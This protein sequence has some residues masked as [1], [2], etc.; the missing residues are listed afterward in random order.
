MN[1]IVDLLYFKMGEIFDQIEQ[2]S[3]ILFQTAIQRSAKLHDSHNYQLFLKNVNEVSGWINEKLLIA[4]DESYRDPTNL[5]GKIQ[6]HQVFDAEVTSNKRRMEAVT[7]VGDLYFRDCDKISLNHSHPFYASIH[8]SAMRKRF[9]C[10]DLKITARCNGFGII[11]N[12]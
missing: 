4:T 5:Q 6:K 11:S 7:V 1:H 9:T 12:L 10:S 2:T 3:I 8:G